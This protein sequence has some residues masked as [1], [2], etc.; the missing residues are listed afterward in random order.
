MVVKAVLR[1]ANDA[2]L[3]ENEAEDAPEVAAEDDDEDCEERDE[4]EGLGGG[5]GYLG[6][7]EEAG[8]P[9]YPGT[10]VD[11]GHGG[12]ILEERVVWAVGA[13][14]DVDVVS[15]SRG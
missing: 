11:G 6:A 7:V 5:G 3:V 10:E 8:L 4:A 12:M 2:Q 13:D 1:G 15:L 14:V 9:V